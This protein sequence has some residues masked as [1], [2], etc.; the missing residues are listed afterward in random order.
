MVQSLKK[1]I[2]STKKKSGATNKLCYCRAC[3]NKLGENHPELKTIVDKTDR[4]LKHFKNCQN[5]QDSYSQQEKDEV[6]TVKQ[7]NNKIL[8]KR[9]RNDLLSSDLTS[10]VTDQHSQLSKIRRDSISSRSS[11]TSLPFQWSNY[12]PMDSFIAQT[13]SSADKKKFH[14]YLLRIT[15]SYGFPLSW[16]ILP[17][18]KTLSNEILGDAIKDFDNMMLE[19]LALDRTGVTLSFDGWTNVREQKLMGTVLMSSEGQPYIWKAV[20]I[21]SER[22]ITVEVMSKIEEMISE[23]DKLEI[24][25]LS[26]V[27]DSAPTYN[28]A[29]KRLRVQYRAIVFLPCFAHQINLCVREIFKVSSNLK[30]TSEQALKI[31]AYFKNTNN[32]YFIGQLQDIQKEIYG[33]YIQPVV[34]GDT[35]WNSYFNCCASINSTKNALRD[36]YNIIMNKSFWESLVTLEQLLAPYCCILNILQTDKARLHE[37]VYYY[38]AWTGK[39]PTSILTEFDDFSQRVKYPFDDT[40]IAQ[41]ENDVHKYWYWVRSAYPKI[42]TVASHI[43]E[44]CVNAASIERLWSSMGFFHTKTRN[45]LKFS[46]VLNMAKLRAEITY[47]RCK[48]ETLPLNPTINYTELEQQNINL[49]DQDKESNLNNEHIEVNKDIEVDEDIEVNEKE[50]SDI[51]DDG[52]NIEEQFQNQLG[53]LLE[54]GNNEFEFDT[55][56]MDVENTEHP[57]QNNDAK[58]DLKIIFKNNLRCPF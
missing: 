32:K 57:A 5:F 28:A 20:D 6:F 26:I 54:M 49:D 34:P 39:N 33:K 27:T 7:E 8:G 37:L 42:G 3:F 44:I 16:I 47:N 38:K 13:L 45:R 1:Y 23:I 51:L 50:D 53:Q 11:L 24:P 12:G 43:F 17:D 30:T 58:W 2:I 31:A 36:I 9:T 21:S 10:D 4:I 15:I 48:Q 40:S 25:L 19:K 56:D 41:F 52:N 35:R 29:K 46:H 22:A 14:L 55:D 18:R